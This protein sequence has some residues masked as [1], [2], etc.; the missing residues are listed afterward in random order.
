MYSHNRSLFHCIY[1]YYIQLR[2]EPIKFKTGKETED[3]TQ[4]VLRLA[5]ETLLLLNEYGVCVFE[6]FLPSDL[7]SR[8]AIDGENF[9]YNYSAGIKKSI[10]QSGPR[11]LNI[12]PGGLT[13]EVDGAMKSS[14]PL[15]VLMTK[16]FAL[17][18]V[19][20]KVHTGTKVKDAAV[21]KAG[22]RQG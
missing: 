9:N 16:F 21:Y 8:I 6:D 12:C 11:R 22:V 4:Y 5:M 7:A 1:L 20:A 2:G 18:H 13:V 3:H 10:K 15:T 17:V 14:L 19:C